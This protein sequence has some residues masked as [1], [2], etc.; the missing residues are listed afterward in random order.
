MKSPG[1]GR[2]LFASFSIIGAAILFLSGCAGSFRSDRILSEIDPYF[3]FQ[4]VQT[5][6]ALLETFQGQAVW[7]ATSE[8]GAFRG[9]ARVAL[10]MPD[11][12]W[13]KLEGPFGIDLA[14]ASV[15][16]D[17]LLV[18]SPMLKAA[19]SGKVDDPGMGKLLP[20]NMAFIQN[21]REISGLLVPRDTL[22]DGLTAFCAEKNEFILDF[23]SGEHI[24]IHNKGP[25]VSR[26][27]KRDSTGDLVWSWDAERFKSQG[28]IR[29][30]RLIRMTSEKNKRM[31]LFYE[32]VKTNHAMHKGWCDVPIPKGVETKSIQSIR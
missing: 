21:V 11:S 27:E 25:V 26:W 5:H 29:I 32:T 19:Y 12:L 31:T 18:F 3:L 9:T 22:L 15:T 14:Y 13:L 4:K 6:A 20:S 16:G 1:P 28:G 17:Q 23:Q 24:R 30:P 2:R 8:D 10:R 7:T